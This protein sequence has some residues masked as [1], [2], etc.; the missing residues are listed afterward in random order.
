M[1]SSSDMRF[2]LFGRLMCFILNML[3]NRSLCINLRES[4]GSMCG[5]IK[6]ACDNHFV[7][8]SV[9]SSVACN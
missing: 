5:R 9:S 4:L 8:S 7:S 2:V 6:V 1:K 3:C